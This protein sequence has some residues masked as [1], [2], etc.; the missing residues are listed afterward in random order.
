MNKFEELR[1]LAEMA[2]IMKH[3]HP[4]TL[5]WQAD[6]RAY[7]SA[8]NPQTILALLD[9]IELQHEALESAETAINGEGTI[10]G[11]I[12]CMDGYYAESFTDWL[13]TYEAN[14]TRAIA[15]YNKFKEQS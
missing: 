8:A 9:L 7:K 5:L 4:N 1:K 11:L 15:A 2:K 10:G 3:P 13:T 6:A 14:T 12:Q